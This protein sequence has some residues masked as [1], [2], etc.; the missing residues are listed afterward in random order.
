MVAA[1]ALYTSELD[2]A[3]PATELAEGEEALIAKRLGSYG[4]LQNSLSS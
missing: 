4:H 1:S 2:A 3:P